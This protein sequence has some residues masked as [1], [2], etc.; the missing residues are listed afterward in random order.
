MSDAYNALLNALIDVDLRETSAH[1]TLTAL[2]PR[3]KFRDVSIDAESV[4]VDARGR[5]C[6]LGEAQATIDGRAESVPL[7]ITGT[8]RNGVA[9]IDDLDIDEEKFLHS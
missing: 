4:D 2:N 9:E 8:F 5:V 1:T 7:L 6:A 3:P